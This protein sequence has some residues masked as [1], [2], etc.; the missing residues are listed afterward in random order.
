M[1]FVHFRSPQGSIQVGTPKTRSNYG[2]CQ[3]G[4]NPQSPWVLCISCPT[5][6]PSKLEYQNPQQPWVLRTWPKPAVTM[7]F[8]HFRSP[9][10]SIQVGTPKTRS[11]YGFC[12]LDQNPQS[13]WVLCISC[14]HKVPSKLEHQKPAVTMGFANLAKTHSHHGFCAFQVPTR[15]HPSWNTKTRSN[16]GFCQLGQNPQSPRVLCISWLDKVPFKSEHVNSPC[17]LRV[18]TKKLENISKS[19]NQKFNM[20]TPSVRMVQKK[21][22]T[23]ALM[24][25]SRSS[26]TMLRASWW[27]H[28]RQ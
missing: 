8:V 9:Q 21:F 23:W 1:G 19:K 15:F 17:L 2:F 12:Q 13:P 7:G 10:G 6:F 11:N 20:G 24:E 4:Q 22:L 26:C 27:A 28:F 25:S 18:L 16:H 3:L 14:P 5:K